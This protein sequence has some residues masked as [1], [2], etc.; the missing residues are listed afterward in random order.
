[1]GFFC[2]FSFLTGEVSQAAQTRIIIIFLNNTGQRD[3]K[4]LLPGTRRGQG[5]R[6]LQ[7]QTL[8]SANATRALCRDPPFGPVQLQT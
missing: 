6:R 8:K 4:E 1:M 5:L 3:S 2:F 7:S